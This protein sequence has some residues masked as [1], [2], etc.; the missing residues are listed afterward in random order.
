MNTTGV[1]APM[2]PL[3]SVLLPHMLLPLNVFEPRYR[4][5]FEELVGEL[6]RPDD[7]VTSDSEPRFG[8][9]LIERGSEIGGGEVR[10]KVATLATVLGAQLLEDGRWG[11]VALGGER[12][13]VDEWLEDD[14]YPRARVRSW[15]DLDPPDAAAV[16]AG[17]LPGLRSQHAV[18]MDLM[19]QSGVV[20]DE[21]DGPDWNT[22]PVKLIWQVALASPLGSL[23][24]YRLLCAPGATERVGLL[25]KLLDEQSDLLQGRL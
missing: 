10:S 21:A 20:V 24:R 23:D 22:E 13:R 5:M 15:P 9:A 19:A 2:F 18:L 25:A 12:V 8:V 17:A 14:P 1:V 7:Q 16:L 3:G 4:V 11:V 6:P